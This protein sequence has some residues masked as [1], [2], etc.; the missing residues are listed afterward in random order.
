MNLANFQ[1]TPF[2]KNAPWRLLLNHEPKWLKADVSLNESL[3]YGDNL[4]L[5]KGGMKLSGNEIVAFYKSLKC[6]NNP[7]A[8]SYKNVT[9]FYRF[10]STHLKHVTPMMQVRR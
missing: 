5:E 7:I 4:H 3:F 8:R 2:L 9:S 6:H 1:K 10:V